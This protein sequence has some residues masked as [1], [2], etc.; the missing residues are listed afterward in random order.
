M[1]TAEC[2]QGEPPHG[3]FERI[4]LLRSRGAT[5]SAAEALAEELEARDLAGDPRVMCDECVRLKRDWTCV[6]GHEVRPGQLRNC[7]FFEPCSRR[8]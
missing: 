4:K 3:R 1:T 5:E 7:S 2:L 8:A 6:E